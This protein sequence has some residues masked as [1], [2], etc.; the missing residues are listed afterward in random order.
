MKTMQKNVLDGAEAFETIGVATQDAEGNFRSQE[1][2]MND[3]ILALA[4]MNDE[5]QRNALA[6]EIFGN[7]YTEILPLLN[8][9]TD[10]LEGQKNAAHELGLVIDGEAITA[11]AALGD[12]M[13]D[14]KDSLGM[15]VTDIAIQLMPVI[16]QLCDFIIAHMPQIQAAIQVVISV[17]SSIVGVIAQVVSAVINVIPQVVSVVN[18]I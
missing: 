1:A 3:T 2:V 14:I 15:V 4:G 9:G 13:A 17:V 7:Q 6:Q 5:T 16:Q 8:Q 12:T 10:A 18:K 11:G